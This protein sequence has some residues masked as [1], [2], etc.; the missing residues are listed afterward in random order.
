MASNTTSAPTSTSAP[1][2][3]T[4]II[5]EFRS[6][7]SNFTTDLLNSSSE[8]FKTRAAFIKAQ[9]ETPYIL[10]FPSSFV[11]LDVVR[12][13]QGSVINTMELRFVNTS[14]PNNAEIRN[15]LN[16]TASNVTGFDIE[17]DS[18]LVNDT[19]AAST[20]TTVVPTTTPNATT[21][22]STT[23]TIVTTST[24]TATT[25]TS[26][27]TT[28]SSGVCHKINSSTVFPLVLLLWLLS[29]QQ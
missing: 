1:T 25:T 23:K 13:R 20:T 15:V 16:S 9:I 27:A 26:T 6:I 8:A 7:Q 12:F 21:T 2:F 4:L 10:A 19:A 18:I 28:A 5:V 29:N 17:R 3:T 22:T 24:T 11:S 14:V